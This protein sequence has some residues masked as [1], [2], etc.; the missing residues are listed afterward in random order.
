MGEISYTPQTEVF[1]RQKH[2]Q[3]DKYQADIGH[4]DPITGTDL[5]LWHSVHYLIF[6]SDISFS[7]NTLCC[8]REDSCVCLAGIHFCQ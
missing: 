3:Y 4:V 5:T 2:L 8:K 6:E 1:H 7:T